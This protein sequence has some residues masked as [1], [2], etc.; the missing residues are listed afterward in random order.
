VGIDTY[1][2]L[3]ATV[4]DNDPAYSEVVTI[5]GDAVDTNTI[6]TYI[7]TYD[8]PADASTNSPLQQTITITVEDTTAPVITPNGSNQTLE[9]GIDTYTELG[10]T[11]TDNDPAY[12]EVVTIGGDAVDTNTIGTY[13][14]TYDAPADA[15]TNSP[16][17]QTITITVEDTT[18]PVITLNGDNPQ[19]LIVGDVYANFEL[20]AT[21]TDNS[22]EIISPVIDSSAVDTSVAGTY[23]VTY[24]ATDSSN[25]AAIQVVRTVHVFT[26][27]ITSDTGDN[28][29]AGP[30]DIIMISEGASVSGN[31]SS[32]GGEIIIQEGASV[33]GNISSNGGEIIIQDGS[34][35][36]GNVQMDNGGTVTINGSILSG[37][38][39]G[40]DGV[41]VIITDSTIAGN[42]EITITPSVLITGNTI[43]GNLI[44]EDNVDVTVENNMVLGSVE[45]KNTSG[46]CSDSGN[47]VIG[48][49]EGCP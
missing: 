28:I 39:T 17:Q 30:G 43:N 5:G 41:D 14:V 35:I 31:I 6:G 25:N 46:M 37:N 27:I 24:D 16:L 33:S 10:A 19:D 34:N 48:S 13:I 40:G 26:E 45:I 42:V 4:T 11:V 8:A 44:V 3:G 15:S 49:F 12:S 22:G 21:V 47:T 2:E 9:V 18:A 1:T 36:S 29:D 38:I 7:V 20:G 32:D 23:T